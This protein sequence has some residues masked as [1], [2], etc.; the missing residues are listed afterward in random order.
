MPGEGSGP[1]QT[2]GCDA[3]PGL[4][5]LLAPPEEG[6]SHSRS[7]VLPW[8]QPRERGNSTQA[9]VWDRGGEVCTR[10]QGRGRT[11]LLPS[12]SS[13]WEPPWSTLSRPTGPRRST[14]CPNPHC[15]ST[16]GQL[17]AKG[18]CAVD[19]RRAMGECKHKYRCS[20]MH[21]A[22][23]VPTRDCTDTHTHTYTCAHRL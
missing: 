23:V 16:E 14:E 1:Q 5:T 13:S 6:D 7:Q 19:G 2:P 15:G 20:H 22:R 3:L 11:H 4:G 18:R 8:P 17:C 9:R 10:G 12:S 21:S